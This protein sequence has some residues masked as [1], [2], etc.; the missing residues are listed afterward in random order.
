[1]GQIQDHFETFLGLIKAPLIS[2]AILMWLSEALHDPNFYEWTSFAVG[3]TP[4]AFY[5]FDEIAL[6]QPLLRREVASHWFKLLERPFEIKEIKPE[7]AQKCR[8]KYLDHLLILAK[9]DHAGHIL[10]YFE[11][12]VGTMD[13]TLILYFIRSVWLSMNEKLVFSI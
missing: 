10:R 11:E 8:E 7:A 12:R 6:H 13:S 5:L 1:M 4:V 2:K 9:L 3:E